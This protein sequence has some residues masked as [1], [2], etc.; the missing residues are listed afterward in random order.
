M[1]VGNCSVTECWP[2]Y[3]PYK[4]GKT[5]HVPIMFLYPV[6]VFLLKK[7]NWTN[8]SHV[9]AFQ[10]LPVLHIRR[11]NKDNLEIVLHIFRINIC[12]DPSLELSCQ[13][14]SNEG[15]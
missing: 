11:Y 13:N 15:S 10:P 14:G 3:P 4:L 6:I 12:C 1:A 8:W 7:H 9:T 2:W 5:V